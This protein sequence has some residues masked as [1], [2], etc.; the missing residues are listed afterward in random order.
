MEYTTTTI[1]ISQRRLTIAPSRGNFCNK[2]CI[3]KKSVL[4]DEYIEPVIEEIT[5]LINLDETMMIEVGKATM[6]EK[7]L[8][9]IPYDVVLFSLDGELVLKNLNILGGRKIWIWFSLCNMSTESI[10]NIIDAGVELI[11]INTENN[12]K[13]LGLLK[14]H[15]KIK[16]LEM[17]HT[18]P[19]KYNKR[20]VL[21]EV[22]IRRPFPGKKYL[23]SFF[24]QCDEI[25]TI[26]AYSSFISIIPDRLCEKAAAIV[27][28]IDGTNLDDIFRKN[29]YALEIDFGCYIDACTYKRIIEYAKMPGVHLIAV[30]G[31]NPMTTPIK[32]YAEI[33]LLHEQL[34]EIVAENKNKIRYARTKAIPCQSMLDTH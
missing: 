28:I 33:I 10:E 15:S 13:Y 9:R 22:A 25:Q 31:H 12:P 29:F 27:T 26:R 1:S 3:E 34:L 11:N 23:E 18:Q 21:N 4:S 19:C 8:D 6:S 20:L 16:K 24:E 30:S 5:K 2:I 32:K 7:F 14:D 17:F